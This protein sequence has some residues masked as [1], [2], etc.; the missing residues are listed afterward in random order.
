M[1]FTVGYAIR[2]SRGKEEL[3]LGLKQATEKSIKL[4]IAGKLIGYGGTVEPFDNS[5][6]ESFIREF[7]EE[8]DNLNLTIDVKDV[9]RMAH[10]EIRNKIKPSLMLEYI[11]LRNYSGTPSNDG[12]LLKAEWYP[13]RPLPENVLNADKLILPR[14]INGEKL[15]GWILYDKDMKVIEHQI[16]AVK[17]LGE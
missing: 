14:I 6:E 1:T 3:L 7:K 10:I 5:I 12:E 13:A 16:K 11:L 2:G 4:G 8:T 15:E 9:E 17:N